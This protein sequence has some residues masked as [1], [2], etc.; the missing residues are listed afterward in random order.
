MRVN[1]C[2]N[3][4][5]VQSWNTADVTSIDVVYDMQRVVERKVQK[6]GKAFKASIPVAVFIGLVTDAQ[7]TFAASNAPDK[8]DM[9]S[10]LEPL[11]HMVQNLALPVGIVISTWGMIELMVGNPGGKQKVKMSLIGYAGIFLIPI[12]FKMIHDALQ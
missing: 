6:M 12:A 7:S 3:G 4:A 9:Y 8:Y 11:I 5:A 2:T 10:K 1:I